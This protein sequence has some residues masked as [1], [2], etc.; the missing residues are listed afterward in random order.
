MESEGRDEDT[1]GA[2]EKDESAPGGG[3]TDNTVERDRCDD[4]LTKDAVEDDEEG[5]SDGPAVVYELTLPNMSSWDM[6]RRRILRIHVSMPSWRAACAD[7][8]HN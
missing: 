6:A 7:V 8:L 4:G 5:Y 2:P 1:P 3:K